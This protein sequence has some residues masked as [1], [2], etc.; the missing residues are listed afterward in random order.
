MPFRHLFVH[1]NR[2]LALEGSG[3]AWHCKRFSPFIP[4]ANA[5]VLHGSGSLEITELVK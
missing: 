4:Y 3:S 5:H 2:M 1:E